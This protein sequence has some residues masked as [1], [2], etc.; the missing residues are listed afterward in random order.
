MDD[1]GIANF[2]GKSFKTKGMG[3]VRQ[4]HV[5]NESAI[6]PVIRLLHGAHWA[7]MLEE[8][9]QDGGSRIQGL[10]SPLSDL[11][12]LLWRSSDLA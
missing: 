10:L 2:L 5:E 8:N 9:E 7:K 4:T 12:R 3:N 6:R 1:R 11:A